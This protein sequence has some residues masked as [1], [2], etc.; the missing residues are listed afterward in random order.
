MSKNTLIQLNLIL[1]KK[2][3]EKQAMLTEKSQTSLKKL[4]ISDIKGM[5]GEVREKAQEKS[6]EKKEKAKE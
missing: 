4:S 3:P 1:K 2:R 6:K 5:F